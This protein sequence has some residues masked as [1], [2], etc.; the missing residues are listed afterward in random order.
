MALPSQEVVDD[1]LGSGGTLDAPVQGPAAGDVVEVAR[2]TEESFSVQ[3]L[4]KVR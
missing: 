1:G 3:L 2:V 4:N